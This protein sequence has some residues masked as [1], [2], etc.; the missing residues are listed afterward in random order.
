L[1][2]EDVIWKAG[3][4]PSDALEQIITMSSQGLVMVSGVPV[5]QLRELLREVRQSQPENSD[6]TLSRIH[7]ALA[8]T[9]ATI[10]LTR[11]GLRSAPAVA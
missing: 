11:S 2:I 10:E 5:E 3:D 6:A 9:N 1:P 8:N 7:D 4:R